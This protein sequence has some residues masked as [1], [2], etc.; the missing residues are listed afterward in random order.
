MRQ[1]RIKALCDHNFV[2][3][4]VLFKM[5]MYYFPSEAIMMA[6]KLNETALIREVAESVPRS[7]SEWNYFLLYLGKNPF[8][9]ND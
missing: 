1:V 4:I 3:I 6:L 5:M 8:Y 2:S 7:D 9:H